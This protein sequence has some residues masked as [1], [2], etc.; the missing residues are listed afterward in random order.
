METIII[1]CLGED[2]WGRIL[3]QGSNRRYYKTI[4]LHPDEG[5]ENLS[6]EDKLYYLQSL[7]T[8]VP[9]DDPEGEPGYICWNPDRFIL[10]S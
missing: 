10:E 4:E 7:S 3:F 5:F 2:Y 1:R 9:S 8:S 6:P